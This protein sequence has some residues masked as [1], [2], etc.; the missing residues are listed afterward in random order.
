MSKLLARRV[1]VVG[2][3]RESDVICRRRNSGNR[4]GFVTRVGECSVTASAEQSRKLSAFTLVELLVV[5]A[6]IAILIA[7]LLPAV[8]AARE[9]ARRAQCFNHIKQLGI[10][11]LNYESAAGRFPPAAI[12]TRQSS[13]FGGGFPGW[14]NL[15]KEAAIGDGGSSWIVAILPYIEQGTLQEGWDFSL[16]VAAN[17]LVARNDIAI[18]YCPTRRSRVR[19]SDIDNNQMFLMWDKGG[20]DYGGCAGGGNTFY[21]CAPDTSG[22]SP[23]CHH[24]MAFIGFGNIAKSGPNGM[25]LFNLD[26]GRKIADIFDG[27]SNTLATGEMQRIYLPNATQVCSQKSDDGWAVGGAA[28]LFDTDADLP[29]GPGFTVGGL[30]N[31][32]FQNPGSEHPGGAQFGMVDGSARFISENVNDFVF[33]GMGTCAGG[34]VDGA[35]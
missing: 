2:V 19:Q 30:N 24:W 25:G 20:N 18:L 3:G 33:Q 35:N 4:L 21:D 10:G 12:P 32:Y 8:Q 13:F 22:C 1:T 31:D 26:E 7:M 9:A 11:L 28:T 23:P 17:E 5:I 6:I 15:F 14:Y 27:T 29:A 34:E 16:S